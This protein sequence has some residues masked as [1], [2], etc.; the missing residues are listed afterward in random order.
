MDKEEKDIPDSFEREE[1][2]STPNLKKEIEK[3][4]AYASRT[5]KKDK[6]VNIRMSSNDL[7]AL[8]TIAVEDGIPY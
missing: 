3:H 1:W 7:E 2:K 8:K 5:L 4:K 6:R